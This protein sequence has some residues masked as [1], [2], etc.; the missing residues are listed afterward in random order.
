MGWSCWLRELSPQI[1]VSALSFLLES[2]MAD[3]A[4]EFTTHLTSTLDATVPTTDASQCGSIWFKGN[5]GSMVSYG[6]TTR[7]CAKVDNRHSILKEGEGLEPKA[8]DSDALV[9][10]PPRS[11]FRFSDKEGSI[12]M[13]FWPDCDVAAFQYRVAKHR[14]ENAIKNASSGLS[15]TDL[16]VVDPNFTGALEM[17]TRV[18]YGIIDARGAFVPI[19]QPKSLAGLHNPVLYAM[20]RAKASQ[21]TPK[22]ERDQAGGKSIAQ[23]R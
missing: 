14:G 1:C 16:S 11:I 21:D 2:N 20:W 6:P 23:D 19:S 10:D 17:T 22:S 15:W 8:T 7:S 12:I 4:T 13:T 3:G 9:V 5:N 18:D